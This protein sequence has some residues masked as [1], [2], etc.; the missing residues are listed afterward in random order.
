MGRRRQSPLEDLMDI[1]ARLPWKVGFVLAL[2]AYLVFHY[3]ASLP[4]VPIATGD[5]KNFGQSLGGSIGRQMMVTFSM[6]LQYLVPF[7]LIIGSA[8]S[9]FRQRR[10]RELHGEV[11]SNPSRDALEK[12]SWREFEGLAAETF[13]RKGYRVVERGGDGPDGGVDL[14]LYMG[15]DKY[16]VQCK[17]WK[18]AKV[19]VAT[20][21]ELYG[22]MT[23]EHA[24]GGFVVASGE[25]SDEAQKFAE[26]RSIKLVATKSLL[27]MIGGT[28]TNMPPIKAEPSLEPACPKCG[29]AMVQRVAKTGNMAGN[30]FWGCSRFPACRGVRN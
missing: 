29:S 12:M 11:A 18:V 3:F 8:V 16:L 5:L 30:T 17:Q 25:F 10:Q 26:G 15:S 24:V 23:A 20:V 28:T 7:A 19:G 27:S 1:S 6:F 9:F 2:I 14:E 21:R 4:P 13:R 22:V